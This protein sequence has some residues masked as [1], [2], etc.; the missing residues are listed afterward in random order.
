MNPN[1]MSREDWLDYVNRLRLEGTLPDDVFPG[2]N[3]NYEE[4]VARGLVKPQRDNLLK[5]VSASPSDD[6][7]PECGATIDEKHIV[8]C[9]VGQQS[10]EEL[11]ALAAL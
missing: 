10:T 6:R 8:G 4:D 2:W 1:E 9:N 3:E 5:Y 7:C 11:E